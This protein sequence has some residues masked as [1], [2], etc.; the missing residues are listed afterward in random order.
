KVAKMPKAAQWQGQVPE[1][2]GLRREVDAH[3][4]PQAQHVY[5]HHEHEHYLV[6]ER[7]LDPFEFKATEE[8]LLARARRIATWIKT[9]LSVLAFV[10][11]FLIGGTLALCASIK[12]IGL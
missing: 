5:H 1:V 11:V 12:L 9:A 6:P 3:R 8:G 10:A 4:A 7:T 2:I